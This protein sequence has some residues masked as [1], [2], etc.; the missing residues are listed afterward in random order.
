VKGHFEG[1]VVDGVVFESG[2]GYALKSKPKDLLTNFLWKP[3]LELCNPDDTKSERGHFVIGD[4]EYI[5]TIRVAAWNSRKELLDYIG[6][7]G[8]LIFTSSNSHI[9]RLRQHIVDSTPELPVARGVQ[10][11]GLHRHEGGWTSLYADRALSSEEAEERLFYVGTPMDNGNSM[12]DGPPMAPTKLIDEVRSRFDL[13]LQLTDPNFAGA[14]VGYAAASPFAPRLTAK[15]GNRLPFLYAA[16]EK[17][18]GKTSI[19]EFCLELATGRRSRIVKAIGLSEYQ[20]DAAFANANNLLALLDEYRPGEGRLDAQIRKH[21]DLGRKTRG[22][23]KAGSD[24]VYHLNAPM[25]VLGEGFAEDPATLSRGA[26]YFVRKADR[27]TPKLF[28][29][30]QDVPWG[31]YAHELHEQ[32][33]HLCEA[34]HVARFKLAETHVETSAKSADARLRLA[35]IFIAYGLLTL[36]AD[37][38][39]GVFS[40]EL[41]QSV[42]RCGVTT[43]LNGG[44]ESTTNIET[45]LEQLGAV[46]SNIYHPESLVSPAIDPNKIIIRISPS[47]MTV[48]KS[49]NGEAAIPNA[50]LLKRYAQ[51]CR[52]FEESATHR[53]FRRK[54]VRGLL[55]DLTR[56][57]ERCDVSALEYLNEQLRGVRND[58]GYAKVA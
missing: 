47:V 41:I 18:S 24:D 44:S 26:L 45:F 7:F 30:A 35:L 15:L 39:D 4:K 2:G 19:G 6:G 22:T 28:R 1:E 9:A 14:M 23:G 11:Y 5:V 29:E 27:S 31:A 48:K 43:T 46:A 50:Q 10:T 40:D 37:V 16:G 32:A 33:R 12:F 51:D 25:I 21:H 3:F 36:Q 54:N 58:T 56:V 42:L 20:Y 8:A 34:D 17:A 55:L 49:L 13:L 52:F 57:P 38:G 53:N